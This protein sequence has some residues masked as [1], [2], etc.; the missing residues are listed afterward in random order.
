MC[1]RNAS[2]LFMCIYRI[3]VFFPV[4]IRFKFKH[5]GFRPDFSSHNDTEYILKF[6][7]QHA[8]N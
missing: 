4:F 2:S 8:G 6:K 5:T 1:G 7:R 3:T